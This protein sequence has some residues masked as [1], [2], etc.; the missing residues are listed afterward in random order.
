MANYDPDYADKIIYSNNWP[1][2][3]WHLKTNV[4]RGFLPDFN[5]SDEFSQ[6]LVNSNA[7]YYIGTDANFLHMKDFERIG[8]TSNVFFFKRI[9]MSNEI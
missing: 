5:N 2:L 9:N 4:N 3:S 8:N 7:T 6:M 1:A